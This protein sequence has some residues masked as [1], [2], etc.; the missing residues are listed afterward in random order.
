[1]RCSPAAAARSLGSSCSPLPWW[2]S[3]GSGPRPTRIDARG[4]RLRVFKEFCFCAPRVRPRLQRSPCVAPGRQ[5]LSQGGRDRVG[6]D[7]RR[8]AVPAAGDSGRGTDWACRAGTV[9]GRRGGK[10]GRTGLARRWGRGGGRTASAAF[11]HAWGGGSPRGGRDRG[12]RGG[13]PI[14]A[15]NS[16]ADGRC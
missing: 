13:T 1:M 12:P 15:G 16:A 4:S 3:G 10:G 5:Q 7:G 9:V 6:R 11:L 8:G 2:P 14:V